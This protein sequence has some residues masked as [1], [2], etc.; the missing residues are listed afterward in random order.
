MDCCGSLV[1]FPIHRVTSGMLGPRANTINT[2]VFLARIAALGYDATMAGAFR[3]Y[4]DVLRN[5]LARASGEFG[6]PYEESDGDALLTRVP[7]WC[8]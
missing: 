2:G 6:L 5:S 4:Q 8:P 3:P 1:E 7:T